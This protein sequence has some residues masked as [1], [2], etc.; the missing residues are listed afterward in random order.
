MRKGNQVLYLSGKPHAYAQIGFVSLTECDVTQ[1]VC[2]CVSSNLGL[3]RQALWTQKFGIVGL[4]RVRA[5]KQ[6]DAR[7]VSQVDE[8]V[9]AGCGVGQRIAR[10]QLCGVAPPKIR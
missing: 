7:N 6:R 2:M 10:M 4:P 8:L 5:P 9:S 3:G 1:R